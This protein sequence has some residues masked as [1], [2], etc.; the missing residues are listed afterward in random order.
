MLK[1]SHIALIE[2][3]LDGMRFGNVEIIV[4]EGRIV[5]IEQREKFRLTGNT[6][7][8]DLTLSQP[9]PTREESSAEGKE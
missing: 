9:T 3:A 1:T 7:S 8:H 2:K 5:Q 6:G 4:H